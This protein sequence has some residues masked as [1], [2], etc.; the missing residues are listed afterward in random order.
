M[1]TYTVEVTPKFEHDPTPDRSSEDDKPA[2][3]LDGLPTRWRARSIREDLGRHVR[4]GMCSC[5]VRFAAVAC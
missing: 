1:L 2:D 3:P 4:A 5:A